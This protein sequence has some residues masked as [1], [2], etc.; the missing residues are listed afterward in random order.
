MSLAASP[1]GSLELALIGNCAVGALIDD[2]GRVVWGCFPRFDGDPV[3]CSLLRTDDE[4]GVF[5]VDIAD[6]DRAEQ[7]Y[8]ENTAIL[9]TRLFDRNGGGVEITDFAP[10]FRLH[11]RMFRPMMLVRQL[12][13]IGG[14]PRL[15]LGL[16]PACG[17]PA[18]TVARGRR[19][20]GAAT[21][22]AT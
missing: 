2:V 15:T 4:L 10:R 16:W 17:R 5:A 20:P 8:L 13:R 6:F 22:S 11:G 3:F 9:V 12:R 7:H 18:T 1:G 14:S 21:M 19:S